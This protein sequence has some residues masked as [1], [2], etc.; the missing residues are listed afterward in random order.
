MSSSG[1][2]PFIRHALASMPVLQ[3]MPFGR[4]TRRERSIVAVPMCSSTP[5]T[6][7]GM[8]CRPL[9]SHVSDARTEVG[10]LGQEGVLGVATVKRKQ[11]SGS[12]PPPESNAR[13]FRD[14]DLTSEIDGRSCFSWPTEP[15][16]PLR[17]T[18]GRTAWSPAFI[19][20]S[21][22]L[23]KT[24]EKARRGTGGTTS[25]ASLADFWC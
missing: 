25:V 21:W 15:A 4:T 3:T 24:T 18:Q 8:R 14:L 2:T 6:P 12:R 7:S 11:P 5:S 10:A 22:A 23:S 17:L 20:P 13:P 19:A 9:T 16:G 1:S